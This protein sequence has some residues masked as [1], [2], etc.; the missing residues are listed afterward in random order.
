[1]KY[2]ISKDSQMLSVMIVFLIVVL[3]GCQNKKDAIET[4]ALEYNDP[5]INS[6]SQRITQN[7]DQADLYYARAELFYKNDGFD[8]AILDL[9]KALT[10]DSTNIDYLHLL[11]DVY[12]DYFKS[13]QALQV[14]KQATELY[15]ERIPTL[16]KLSEFQMILKQYQESLLTVDRVLKISPQNA[17]AYFMLGMNFKE[18]G[19]TAR[20]INSFQQSVE[21]DPEIIESWI[22]LGQ[23]Q[24]GLGN[25]IALQ[26]FNSALSIDPENI[27][28]LHAKADYYSDLGELENAVNTYREM[29]RADPQYEQSYFNMGLLYLDQDS[30]AKA[31]EQ[32][33]LLIEISPL[34][35]RGYFYRGLSSE[36]MGNNEAAKRDYEQALRLSPDYQNALEGLERI[37]NV[38]SEKK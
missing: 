16:L 23:L 19:D 30:I 37:N 22:Y 14:M 11:A 24:A 32:F 34:H 27:E 9:N 12:I 6:I 5:A 36:F 8:E 1:M 18:M 3:A 25:K 35:I 7:P 2:R 21:L 10:L 33:N 29:V 28:V 26:Y 17:D 20:A 4:P 13:R 15:P 38:L 31:F